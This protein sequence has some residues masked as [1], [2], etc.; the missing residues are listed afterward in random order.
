[1]S[2][3]SPI[4]H[5]FYRTNTHYVDITDDDDNATPKQ[6]KTATP[7]KRKAK[8][9]DKDETSTTKAKRNGT[10]S[11]SKAKDGSESP[12]VTS[13]GME[14]VIKSEPNEAGEVMDGMSV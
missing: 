11:A 12:D 6:A 7:R 3:R 4:S 1:M 5:I 14:E 9:E 13:S 8:G 2:E 10:K